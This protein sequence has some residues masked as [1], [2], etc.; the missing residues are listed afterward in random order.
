[1]EIRS[2]N[3]IDEIKLGLDDKII[4]YRMMNVEKQEASEIF[5]RIIWALYDDEL[6]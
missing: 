2:Q 3:A 1:M 6:K 5:S 4:G